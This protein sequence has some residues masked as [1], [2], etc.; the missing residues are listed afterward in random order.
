MKQK[1]IIV[2]SLTMIIMQEKFQMSREG[3]YDNVKQS[4]Q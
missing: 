3:K 4:I 1:T 2:V